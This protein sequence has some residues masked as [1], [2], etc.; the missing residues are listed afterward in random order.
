MMTPTQSVSPPLHIGLLTGEYPPMQGGVGAFT[1][2]LARAL[3]GQGHAVTVITSRNA[4]PT[5]RALT[6]RQLR[7]PIDLGYARLLA[8]TRRWTWRDVALTAD[9]ALR[10]E[11]DVLN[12]QFQAAAYNMRNP[13]VYLLPWRLRGVTRTAVTFHDL[14]TPYLFPK[15]GALRG[16]VVRLL[17]RQ[18]D[19]VIATNPA[20][21]AALRAWRNGRAVAEIPI[22][23]NVAV[24]ATTEAQRRA[25]RERLGVAADG[26]L[27]GYFGFLNQ[28][29]GPDLLV[30]ALAQLDPAV[31]LVFIG[32]PTGDS[33]AANRP[34]QAQVARQIAALGLTGRVHH[35]GFMPDPEVSAHLAACDLIVLPYRDGVSLRRGTLMAAL[36][37]GCP[38]LTT[39]PTDGSAEL[40]DGL[41][42]RLVPPGDAAVLAAAARA[43]LAD[44]DLRAQ[45]GRGAAALAQRFGW[46]EIAARSADFYAQIRMAK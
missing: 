12:L 10:Y 42:A 29:K 18:A 40:I 11:L 15:A 1:Q 44:P 8:R 2:E 32:G 35:T 7:E 46:P 37:H 24:H 43:L 23:S 27:L 21:A 3:A 5:D 38:L 17:A 9:L 14:R 13:A 20:D 22:G 36:A 30:E 31:Q 41:H 28:S 45:L 16:W 25:V 4:R 19:G 33:D 26:R 6:A 34:F 39:A